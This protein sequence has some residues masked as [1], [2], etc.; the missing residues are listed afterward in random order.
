[1]TTNVAGT[2]A[3]TASPASTTRPP[4]T[5]RYALIL[6]GLTAFGPLSIDMYLPAL[7]AI[8]EE[9]LSV[10]AQVQLTL[11]ACLIGVSAGQL[12]RVNGVRQ[13]GL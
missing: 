8:T 6:G 11:T 5:A 13:H 3:E 2:T 9:L 7:P 4:R 1:M 12:D 10:P